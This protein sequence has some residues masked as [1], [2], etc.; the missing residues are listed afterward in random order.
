[1]IISEVYYRLSEVFS[2]VQTETLSP[3]CKE[4][5]AIELLKKTTLSFDFMYNLSVKKLKV[6]W[7][8][9][10]TNLENRFI[11]SLWSS[12][13]TSVLFALKSDRELRLC[14]N[15]Q[16]LNVIIKQ[17]W[18]SLSLIDK[19]MNCVSDVKVFT[20]IDVKNA[21]YHICI[22]ESDEWKTVFCICYKLYE[23]LIMPFELINVSVSF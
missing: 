11:Q 20:K 21:Y 2:E 3:H 8:Y 15:Y 23:Y 19:I 14:V 18:Y 7:E 5:H 16:S 17:N 6:L 9:L 1:M 12:A 22:C 10:N 4:D 13:E